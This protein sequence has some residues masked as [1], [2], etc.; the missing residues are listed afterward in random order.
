[1][2]DTPK[3]LGAV[4]VTTIPT[5]GIN[6]SGWNLYTVPSGASAIV[7]TVFMCNRNYYNNTS[8]VRLAHV[9]NGTIN[10]LSPIDYLYDIPL[11]ARD[12]FACTCGISMSP[13]D[14]LVVYSDQIGVNFIA[15]GLEIT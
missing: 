2:V 5:S 8:N 6:S 15:E 9:V 13:L 1:M 12:T 7:S 11:A 4:I 3:R 10:N 14:S